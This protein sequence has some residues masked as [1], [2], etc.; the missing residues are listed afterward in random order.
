VAVS[1]ARW[2]WQKP[3]ERR[4]AIWT[5]C[6]LLKVTQRSQN[7]I[8]ALYCRSRSARTRVSSDTTFTGGLFLKA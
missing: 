4:R 1:A 5:K 2:S 8:A 7:Q 3:Q 6:I